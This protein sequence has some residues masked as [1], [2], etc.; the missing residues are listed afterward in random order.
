MDYPIAFSPDLHLD[1]QDWIAFWND[2]PES[3]A[4]AEARLVPLA[5]KGFPLDPQ[6]IQQ[7]L[8]LLANVAGGIALDA[9]KDAVRDRLTEYFKQK[10]SPKPS[11]RVDSVRQPD[12]AYLLVV[13]EEAQ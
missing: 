7:G 3:R 9:L 12:G 2:A 8:V 10:L 11:I 6:M 1:P 5:T 13:T 4:L